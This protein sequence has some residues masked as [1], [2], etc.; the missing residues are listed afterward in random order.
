[1]VGLFGAG[2]VAG[3]RI[4]ESMPLP[5]VSPQSA[6]PVALPRPRPPFPSSPPTVAPSPSPAPAALEGGHHRGL[7]ARRGHNTP[8]LE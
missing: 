7:R 2:G 8:R 1:V 3:W 4:A 5:M 6:S